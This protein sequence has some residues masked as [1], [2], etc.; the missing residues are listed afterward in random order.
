MRCGCGSEQSLEISSKIT[1]NETTLLRTVITR[2]F[3]HSVLK[4]RAGLGIKN[5]LESGTQIKKV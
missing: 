4:K 2:T 1:D 3:V 5:N